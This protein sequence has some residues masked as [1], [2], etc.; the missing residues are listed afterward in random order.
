MFYTATPQRG[1]AIRVYRVVR[2]YTTCALASRCLR[3]HV[4]THCTPRIIYHCP[5]RTRSNSTATLLRYSVAA[6]AK[7]RGAAAVV[8]GTHVTRCTGGGGSDNNDV[9]RGRGRLGGR[10]HMDRARRQEHLLGF[11]RLLPSQRGEVNGPTKLRYPVPSTL[12]HT[13]FVCTNN[14]SCTRRACYCI[15]KQ[16]P[17]VSVVSLQSSAAAGR[18]PFY[19]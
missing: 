14:E 4:S 7:R 6:A 5:G 18:R 11:G 1:S 9:G 3:R 13:L 19:A 10:K 8:A 12:L 15:C 2:E 16:F 17:C